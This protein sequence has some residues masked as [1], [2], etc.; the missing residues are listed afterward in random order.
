MALRSPG[1]G[2]LLLVLVL[3]FGTG[4]DDA[5][6]VTTATAPS[7]AVASGTGIQSAISVEPA[8]LHP[9]FLPGMSCRSNRPFGTRVIIV[10]DGRND[11]SLH[12]LRFRFTD[13]FGVTAFPN[14]IQ[15]GV[16]PMTQPPVSIPSSSPIP[17]PGL[18]PLPPDGL[19][20]PF[21]ASRS[22]PFFLTFGCGPASQGTL[23]VMFDAKFGPG[24]MQ[25]TE[26]R[27]RVSE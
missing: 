20:I 1:Y 27:V 18:A 23:F 6:N 16:F 8:A 9:E 22:L 12:R 25:S 5:R 10:I 14:E 3:V 11:V 15:T 21:G 24:P 2:S 17:I 19:F 7:G 26:L 13:R 4:C